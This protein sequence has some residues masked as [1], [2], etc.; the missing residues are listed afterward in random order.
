M[1]EV[2]KLTEQTD[3]NKLLTGPAPNTLRKEVIDFTKTA[4]PNYKNF[5]A[6]ILDNVLT[7][8]ECADLLSAAEAHGNGQWERA[9]INVGGG[10]QAMYSDVRNC[11]RIIWDDKEVMDRIWK[12][13][14]PHMQEILR[15]ENCHSICGFR[16]SNC[17]WK[18]TRLNE[19]MRF[20]KYVGG[21]YFRT[22]A[23]TYESFSLKL[24]GCRMQG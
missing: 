22:H 13:C 21:E 24:D 12:R 1:G 5:Y 10:R 18:M 2:A 6:V 4:I 11:G 3:L 16:G 17:T 8:N 23:G 7:P 19:R 15:L 14:E 20:L 9:M